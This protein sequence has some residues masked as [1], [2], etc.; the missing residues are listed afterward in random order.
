DNPC[1]PS[2]CRNGASCFPNDTSPYGYT[3][4]CKPGFHGL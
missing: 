3:C 4:L 1:V 2:P